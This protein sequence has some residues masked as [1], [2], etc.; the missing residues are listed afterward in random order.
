MIFFHPTVY[1]KKEIDEKLEE[2]R[3]FLQDVLFQKLEVLESRYSNSSS[4]GH[5]SLYKAFLR[6]GLLN[7]PS[8]E[9]DAGEIASIC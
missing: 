5:E 2:L 9:T 6:E 1:S 4:N 8:R 7:I 3:V